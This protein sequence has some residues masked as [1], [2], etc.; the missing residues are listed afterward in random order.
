MCLHAIIHVCEYMHVCIH[1][2]ECVSVC[3]CVC[4]QVCMDGVCVQVHVDCSLCVFIHMH[5]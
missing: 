3:I 4:L 2:C 5:V 1:M